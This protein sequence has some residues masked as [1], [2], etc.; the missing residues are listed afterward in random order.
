MK[1]MRENNGVRRAALAW[2]LGIVG[3]MQVMAASAA[4]LQDVRH[5]ELPGGKLEL[6]L[7]FDETP[8][9]VRGYTIERPARIALDLVG[10]KS[11]VRQRHINLGQG[12]ARSLTVVEAADRTRMIVSLAQPGGYDTRADGK[13]L[14]VTLGGE[15][16]PAFSGAETPATPAARGDQVRDVDFRRGN[17]GEGR[18]VVQLGNSATPVDVREEGG[19]IQVRFVGAKLPDNLRRRLDVTDFGTPVRF[20]DARRDGDGT[21]VVI[22]PTGTWEYL[23]YQAD[24]EFS[25]SVKPLTKHEAETR[26]REANLYTGDRIS[27]NFQQV[28]VRAVLQLIAEVT[29]LNVVVSDTVVGNITLRLENVPWDQALDLILKTKGLDK[30]QA[31]NVL[32]VAPANE[33]AAQEKLEAENKAQLETLAPLRTEYVRI[34]Y[35]RATDLERLIRNQGG[36]QADASLLSPRG[37]VSVDERTNTL[38]IQDTE[39]KL[40]SIRDVVEKL[41]VAVQ[42][43]LIEAR[44]VIASNDLTD[45]LGIRWGGMAFT[46]RAP[47]SGRGFGFTGGASN[48]LNFGTGVMNGDKIEV[49]SPGDMVVDLGAKDARATR[50]SLGFVDISS[51]ILELELSALAAEGQGEV[52]ATPKVLTADQQPAVIASGT[53]I[54]Y[55]EASS[56]GATSVSFVEAELRLEVTPRITPEGRIIMELK[57]NND[58]VGN[59][60]AGVPSIDT[61]R[62]ETTVLVNDGETLVLGGIFQHAQT[63]GVDKTPF[64]GDLPWIGRLFRRDYAT[65]KKQELLIFITPRLLKETYAQQ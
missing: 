25:I 6:R 21:L 39:R 17:E 35:A 59:I 29:D 42:Q 37:S 22:E 3:G 61:N 34:N 20:V 57:I 7:R 53:Q 45:E 52:V 55:Q 23:A 58:S 10:A 2:L 46:N 28:E 11:A 5:V 48:A 4:T 15:S 60:I 14:V 30:R 26:R 40:E 54:G 41:D 9:E 16:R 1:S 63:K 19:R 36:S 32:L 18:V 47:T 49:E 64:L 27:M 65:D 51:G 43:V 38:I 31:G 12:N 24:N 62:V 8:P 56:S 50:F 13:E 44:I 33:I